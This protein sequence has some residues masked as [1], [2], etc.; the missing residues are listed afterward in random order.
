MYYTNEKSDSWGL[1][2]DTDTRKIAAAIGLS[3][4]PGVIAGL[5]KSHA[6]SRNVHGCEAWPEIT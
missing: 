1:I 2:S 3:L 4:T 5:W 6:M